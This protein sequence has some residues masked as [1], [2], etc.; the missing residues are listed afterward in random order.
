M[1]PNELKRDGRDGMIALAVLGLVVGAFFAGIAAG[2]LGRGR[3]PE[4]R[5]GPSSFALRIKEARDLGYFEGYTIADDKWDTLAAK[6]GWVDGF[7][8][9]QLELSTAVPQMKGTH[10][11]M[12]RV[13]HLDEW[14]YQR[15]D[16]AD[17]LEDCQ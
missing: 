10:T 14:K 1:E 17:R 12:V 15:V 5:L 9:P 11:Y 7:G 4:D 8:N 3:P 16:F 2:R 13:R 6:S